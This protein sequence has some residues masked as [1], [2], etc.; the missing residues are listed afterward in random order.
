MRLWPESV[1][2]YVTG[3]FRLAA[4]PA[5]VLWVFMHA[6]QF[7]W[8]GAVSVTPVWVLLA[9][10]ANEVALLI[11]AARMRLLL[12]LFKMKIGWI[13]AIRIHFQSLFYYFAVPMTVGLE[14]SRFMKIQ[15]IDPPAS[16]SGLAA[17]LLIDRCIGALAALALALLCLPELTF[18]SALP[19]QPRWL[20]TA[21]SAGPV[22]ALIMAA[23]P[24]SRRWLTKFW[25]LT[26]GRRKGLLLAFGLGLLMN[27]VFGFAIE[28]AAIGLG[29]KISLIDALF[30]VSGGMLLV[31]IPVSLAG[32][33]PAEAGTAG[34]LLLLGYDVRHA[35]TVAILPY[36]A[37]LVAAVQGG[38]WE[39]FDGARATF[40]ALSRPN[41]GVAPP[42]QTVE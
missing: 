19:I 7:G 25:D 2:P 16:K 22:V 42:V 14:I 31:A 6:P 27:I 32:L 35:V 18:A 4:V 10:V 26:D 40:A 3:V 28:L 13:A 37:R 20:W 33:G 30:A 41:N 9:L 8:S 39:F 5:G 38:V 11:F 21:L 23:L 1:S 24:A 36:L 29:M 17:A 15:A 34:L 12:R